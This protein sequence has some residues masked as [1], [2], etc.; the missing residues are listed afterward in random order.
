MAG[1]Y[2]FEAEIFDLKSGRHLGSMFTSTREAG[3][4]YKLGEELVL[5]DAIIYKNNSKRVRKCYIRKAE[6]V[7]DLEGKHINC[8]NIF[9]EPTKEEAKLNVLPDFLKN[10]DWREDDG[11]DGWL[12]V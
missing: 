2:D 12:K 6:R 4:P 11:Y 9:V 3:E 8:Y 1:F 5:S 7:N 10:D